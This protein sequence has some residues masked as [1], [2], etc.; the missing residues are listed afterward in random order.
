MKVM[1]TAEEEIQLEK[2]TPDSEASYYEE[3]R[4]NSGQ[5]AST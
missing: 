3:I 2:V 5:I 4:I 1:K